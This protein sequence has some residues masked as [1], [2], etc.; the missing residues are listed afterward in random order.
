MH[1]VRVEHPAHDLRAGVDVGARHVA[2]GP[3]EVD[4]LGHVA[5]RQALALA[6][7]QRAR[8][9]D[10]AAFRAAH[11]NAD[12]GALVR[13][14]ERERLDLVDRDVLVK[15]DAAFRG[16]ARHVVLHAKRGEVADR[17]VVHAHGQQHLGDAP[18]QLGHR[19][20]VFRELQAARGSVELIERVLE[21]GRV[22]FLER[23][24]DLA[25]AH[26][27]LALQPLA[28]RLG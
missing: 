8:I 16:A 11:R 1:D 13:H 23:T 5:A 25:P 3:E 12:D 27:R 15:A 26:G 14:P 22:P 4:H 17:A 7:R 2:V 18:R 24:R 19:D 28:L 9:D 6:L 20:L 10:D 21:R